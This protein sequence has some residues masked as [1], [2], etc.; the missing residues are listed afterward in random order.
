MFATNYTN[1]H[2]NA[3]IVGA[4]LLNKA[5]LPALRT[6]AYPL[7][8]NGLNRR[9][10]REYAEARRGNSCS[11]KILF[12]EYAAIRSKSFYPAEVIKY[13]EWITAL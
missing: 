3:D 4:I 6:F 12:Y 9:E 7:R 13:Q 2:E 8:L 10:R 11:S 5:R 1:C